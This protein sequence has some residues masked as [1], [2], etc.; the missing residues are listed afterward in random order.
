MIDKKSK[1]IYSIDIRRDDL[2]KKSIPIVKY[3]LMQANF[4]K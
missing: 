4:C 2:Q 3:Y 1:K